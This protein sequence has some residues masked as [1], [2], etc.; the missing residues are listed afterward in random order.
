MLRGGLIGA[1][2]VTVFG[3]LLL[4]GDNYALRL[5]TTVAM[6]VTLATAWNIIGGFAG[7]PSFATA[8]FFGLGAY[9]SGIALSNGIPLSVAW[10]GAGLIVAL[11]AV[12]LGLCILHLRGHYF[13]IGSLVAADVLR[14]ITNVWVSVTGGG[15]GLNLPLP[16]GDAETQAKLFLC[17]MSGLAGA[18][19]CAAW[20][21]TR[22][23]LGVALRCIAQN[24]DAAQVIGIDTGRSKIAALAL[25]SLFVGI[26]GA[27]YA[28]W[29]IYIDPSDVY[30]VSLS[31]KPII[32]TLLGGVGTVTGP[33][34]G[35]FA[36]LGL[37]ELI[38]RNSLEFHSGFLG[39][40]V[41]ALVLFLPAGLGQLRVGSIWTR[42]RTVLP[43]E[44]RP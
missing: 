22:S 4:F 36:F 5:G 28:S 8:A 15:I 23:R 40:L 41:V 21:L 39:L 19:C 26:A 7:Y 30:D 44:A 12:M 34:V 13:A 24:E 9:T 2:A 10:A 37:E 42:I 16:G 6:Y 31:V 35:A 29:T 14:E 1:A 32:M 43:P 25:S 33:I 17:V 11:F 27:I 18:A 38:W 20:T 3:I